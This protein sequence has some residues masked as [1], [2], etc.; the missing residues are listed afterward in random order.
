MNDFHTI[1]VLPKKEGRYWVV[2]TRISKPNAEGII[3]RTYTDCGYANWK[4]GH[5]DRTDYDFWYGEARDGM[6][7]P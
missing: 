6:P 2:M 5:W 4:D 1:A 3:D 7:T